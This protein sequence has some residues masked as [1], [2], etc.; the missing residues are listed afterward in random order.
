MTETG[1]A[2]G[3]GLV[4]GV[5]GWA[6]E[7]EAGDLS[8]VYASN[9]GWHLVEV[10]AVKEPGVPEFAAVRNQVR[11]D[12]LAERRLDAAKPRAQRIA[13]QVKL[14][15]SLEDAAAEEELE[16][17]SAPAFTRASGMTGFQQ[18]AEV[19]AAAF[20]TTVGSVSDPVETNRGWLILR[21]EAKP[22]VDESLYEAQA[23]QIRIQLRQIK[24]ITLYNAYLQKLR[25][26][27]DIED[28]RL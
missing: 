18:N 12:V 25:E 14:G 6:V 11:S 4:P 5:G 9:D 15:E 2:P 24:Q 17:Q 22:P 3:L 1:F 13:G 8:R 20:A 27:A 21:V 26:Q 7:Q 10:V 28:F 16:V 23:P 19:T